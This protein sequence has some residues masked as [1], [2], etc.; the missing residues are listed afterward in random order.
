[1]IYLD[2]NATTRLYQSVYHKHC[3]I[4]HRFFGNPSSLYPAGVEVK[5]MIERSRVQVA[6]FINADL[7]AGDT[8]LFT[9]CATESNNS[10]LHSAIHP[11]SHGK[12][13]IISAVEHPSISVTASNFEKAG[14]KVTKIG[15]DSD[16]NLRLEEL[17]SAIT[18]ETVLV[19]IM[20]VNSETGVI[21][22]IANVVRT[23][24]NIREN[25]IV[26][27]DAVQAA[28]KI[29]ID[30]Q[31]LG[32]DMLTLSGHKF[33]APK[34]VGVLYI[35]RGVPFVPFV[36]GGHQEHSLRAGTENTASI[37]A[38][39]EAAAITK[40]EMASG[41]VETISKLKEFMENKLKIIFPESI[42]FGEKAPRVCN[43]TNIGF[44]NILGHKLVLQLAKKGI[45]VS[46]GTA[47]NS[48]SAKPSTVLTAMNVPNEYIS[49]IRISLDSFNT[50]Q[51][52]IDLLIALEEILRGKK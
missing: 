25:I 44:R 5:A 8:I 47:C 45:Y 49:S 2:N 3:E 19:S 31:A 27:T 13:I 34:G 15:V 26:H 41:S 52:I 50:E 51:N 10:A 37:V 30:V 6:S 16:G 22:D 23:V 48:S 35:R 32:V 14:A 36:L 39:G 18:D 4:L 29:P 1:M 11:N 28:G 38:L 20:Y 43:T 40:A 21:H 9:S 46:S 24:K 42:I 33:H 12:H 17:C 7:S